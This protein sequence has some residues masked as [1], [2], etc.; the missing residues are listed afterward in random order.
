MEGP[1]HLSAD[2][3]HI[4][5]EILEALRAPS[6]L[7]QMLAQVYALLSR[8]VAVDHGALCISSPASPSGYDWAVAELPKAFFD[9]Y[10]DIAE[11]DFVRQAVSLSP[12][13]VVRDSEMLTRPAI[14]RSPMYQRCR[15]FGMPIEHVMSVLLSVEPHWHGGLTLY[16]SRRRPFSERDSALVQRL[17]PLIASAMHT[18]R[19]FQEQRQS[20]DVLSGLLSRR[21]VEAVVYGEGGREV[22]RTPG[23]EGMVHRWYSGVERDKSGLP[24]AWI[25]RY[26]RWMRVG[27]GGEP[28]PGPW[29]ER[30]LDGVLELR[31]IAFSEGRQPMWALL[32]EERRVLGES[33]PLIP[34]AWVGR[35]SKRELEVVDRILRGWGNAL[36][37]DDLGCSLGTVKKHIQH[38]FDALGLSSRAALIA[39]AGKLNA[40]EGRGLGSR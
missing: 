26:G 30:G 6:D 3:Q 8:L 40:E 19:L 39:V 25:D 32:C 9:S 1:L 29:T 37:A 24:R 12:N 10:Q 35:L 38:I 23:L 34:K 33:V 20:V 21:A 2:E 27:N 22:L 36:I 14:E 16:R 31:L 5:W 13:R 18:S 11:H 15:E 17:S 7:N 4:V 28:L